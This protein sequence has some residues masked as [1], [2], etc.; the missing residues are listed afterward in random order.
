M[1]KRRNIGSK[2]DHR[3]KEKYKGKKNTIYKERKEEKPAQREV[4]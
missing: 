4:K 3:E 1:Q 2:P